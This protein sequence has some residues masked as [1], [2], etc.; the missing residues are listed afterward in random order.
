MNDILPVPANLKRITQP[1]FTDD[2]KWEWYDIPLKESPSALKA[3]ATD[4]AFMMTRQS[5]YPKPSWTEFNQKHSEVD[6]NMTTVGYLPIIQAPAHDIDTLNTVV[7][8]A[9]HITQ[10]LN[11]KH[12]VLTVDEALFPKLMELQWSVSEY[13]DILIPRLGGLHTAMNFLRVIGQH[14]E[15]CGLTDVW[16]ETGILGI[17]AAQHAMAGKAYARAIR[18]HKITLQAL[19]QLLLPQLYSYLD[20]HDKE[21]KE[22]LQ[23]NFRS[24]N[25]DLAELLDT[26]STEDFRSHMDNFGHKLQEDNPNSQFWWQYMDMVSIFLHFIRAQCD[27]IWDLHLY[28]FRRMLPFFFRYDHTHYARWGTIYL[29]EMNCLPPEVLQEFQAGNFVVKESSR[30]FNQVSPDHSHE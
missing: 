2:T 10:A 3:Q 22:K 16:I 28:A 26:L 1:P 12:I 15:D 13:K 8:R 6:P 20:E 30:K 19:W 14:M 4:N 9:L 25:Y 17:N 11:Q 24:N 7:Q 23:S 29:S 18:V 5:T 27:G 21:L